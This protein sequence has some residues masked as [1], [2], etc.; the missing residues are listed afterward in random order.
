MA[1]Q[2]RYF[3]P[4]NFFQPRVS[5]FFVWTNDR[6][7]RNKE[8]LVGE[9]VSSRKLF[10]TSSLSF[11]FLFLFF[12]NALNSLR[13]DSKVIVGIIQRRGMDDFGLEIS[14]FPG[15]LVSGPL[16]GISLRVFDF[17]GGICRERRHRASFS[18]GGLQFLNIQRSSVRK[19]GRGGGRCRPHPRCPD[20][21]PRS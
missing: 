12:E 18:A 17:R 1:Q 14:I 4:M 7:E 16:H 5:V 20:V 15:F 6:E 19:Y 21:S 8:E 3:S 9:I 11:F 13:T 10:S 2:R